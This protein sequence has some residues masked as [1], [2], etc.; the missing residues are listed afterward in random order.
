MVDCEE[1]LSCL[2]TSVPPM[3]L[4]TTG[5]LPSFCHMTFS[6]NCL[7]KPSEPS[8]MYRLMGAAGSS[9]PSGDRPPS[10]TVTRRPPRSK[11]GASAYTRLFQSQPYWLSCHSLAI[12]VRL[13]DCEA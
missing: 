12:R 7:P 6:M 2:T 10:L 9:G 5:G 4:P 13:L 3:Y 8:L 1:P 11:C